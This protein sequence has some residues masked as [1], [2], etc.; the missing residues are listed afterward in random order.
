MAVPVLGGAGSHISYTPSLRDVKMFTQATTIQL[1]KIVG[2]T[3]T[4]FVSNILII[5]Q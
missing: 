5:L 1:S 3:L 2:E 4:D